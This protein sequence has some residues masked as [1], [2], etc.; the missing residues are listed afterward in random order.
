MRKKASGIFYSYIWYFKLHYFIQ[1]RGFWEVLERI[2]ALYANRDGHL[3]IRVAFRKLHSE[4]NIE[5]IVFKK[6]YILTE[7]QRI[8][9]K[10][11]FR[12]L[13]SQKHSEN[14]V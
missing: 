3:F 13:H 2:G 1:N 6:L 7:I 14:Y 8:I 12:E 10:I 11:T 4:N 9:Y 5:L